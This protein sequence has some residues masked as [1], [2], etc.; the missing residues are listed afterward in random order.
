MSRD[1][2]D[3]CEEG[4]RE[5]VA[6][7]QAALAAVTRERD[8]AREACKRLAG[9]MQ[10]CPGAEDVP[11]AAT[12]AFDAIA[13]ACGCAEWWYPGQLVNDVEKVV[14]E[15]D[16]F[17]RKGREL[18]HVYGMALIDLGSVRLALG[19]PPDA[20]AAQM[21]ERAKRLMR[22]ANAVNLARACSDP[23][24]TAAHAV[25]AF[26]EAVKRAHRLSNMHPATAWTEVEDALR[27]L[28]ATR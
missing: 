28:E 6:T 10:S 25:F 4:T 24:T 18:C 5:Q 14:K 19:L 3:V 21:V 27:E 7:L 16:E 12:E 17:E 2:C 23:A 13:V 1:D 11:D 26:V 15:R 8:E 22:F 9:P 20:V